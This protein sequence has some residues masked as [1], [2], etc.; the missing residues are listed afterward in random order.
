M[1]QVPCNNSDTIIGRF[2]TFT[3]HSIK[4]ITEQPN[5]YFKCSFL[6]YITGMYFLAMRNIDNVVANSAH[7]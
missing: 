3:K 5:T 1:P 4:N 6:I 2:H 7:K